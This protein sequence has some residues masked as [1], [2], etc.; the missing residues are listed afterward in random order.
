[1]YTLLL[2]IYCSE[3]AI[4]P[5]LD[6]TQQDMTTG[7]DQVIPVRERKHFHSNVDKTGYII[8]SV[9]YMQTI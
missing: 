3:D 1:M 7:N 2:I 9:R 5:N 6:V 8:F 4:L